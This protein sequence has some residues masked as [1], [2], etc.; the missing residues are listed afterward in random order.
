MSDYKEVS[1]TGVSWQRAHL[2]TIANSHGGTPWIKFQ[3]ERITQ[4]SDGQVLH[5]PVGELI[6]EMVDPSTVFNVINPL[7]GDIVGTA[8]YQDLQVLLYSLYFH[9][10][11]LRDTPVP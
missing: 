2:I 7:T 11:G 3:E 6:E 1:L 10:V 8:T 9:L 4:L 5:S